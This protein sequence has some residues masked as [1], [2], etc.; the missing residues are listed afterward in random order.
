MQGLPQFVPTDLK[1]RYL[2][3]LLQVGFHT[4]DFGSFVSPKAVPQMQD[5]AE[6]VPQ[7]EREGS[8][9]KLLAIVLNERGAR[10][11]LAH[12][13]I[14]LLGYPYSLSE[15]FSQRNANKSRAQAYDIMQRIQELAQ[16]AG[17]QL[18]VYLSMGFGNPYG[19]PWSEE[20][21]AQA[22]DEIQALGPIDTLSLADTAGSA[23]P[24]QI[25]R[26]FRH[27]QQAHPPLHFGAHFHARPDGWREKVAAAWEGG[28]RRFDGALSGYGGCPFASDEMVGNLATENLLAFLEEQDARPALDEAALQRARQEAPNVFA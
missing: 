2:N 20:R 23:E 13:Q 6:V 18:V 8:E 28:C 15:T 12:P 16:E 14:D 7:L 1:V 17:R 3:Q 19:D 22:V 25:R 21:V 11:A 27:L 24:E 4:L 5:T 26:L 10:D 9:T